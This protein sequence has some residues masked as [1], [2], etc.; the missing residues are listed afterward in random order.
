MK[1]FVIEWDVGYDKM[2]WGDDKELAWGDLI[3][4]KGD[5]FVLKKY[6][7]RKSAELDLPRAKASRQNARVVSI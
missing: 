7:T 4:S 2:Y 3:P 6:K 1:L 5:L